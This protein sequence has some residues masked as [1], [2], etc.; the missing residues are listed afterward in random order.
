MICFW[1]NPSLGNEN[2]PLLHEHASSFVWKYQSN[3][4]E[5]C[6]RKAIYYVTNDLVFINALVII[7]AF[8]FVLPPLLF[9]DLKTSYFLK[10]KSIF[11]VTTISLKFTKYIKIYLL[12]Q[13]D[14]FHCHGESVF[15]LGIRQWLLSA[16]FGVWGC[17]SLRQKCFS[18]IQNLPD[19]ASLAN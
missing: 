2:Y 13:L 9:L 8:S 15:E 6:L 7:F 5:S 4:C 1:Q 14:D 10:I 18:E 16:Q 17:P 11:I 19:L 3:L 12:R